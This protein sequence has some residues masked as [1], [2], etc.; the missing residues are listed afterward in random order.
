M[1]PANGPLRVHTEGAYYD[2]DDDAKNSTDAENYS[3]SEE[4]DADANEP[5][6]L[7]GGKRNSV[8]KPTAKTPTHSDSEDDIYANEPNNVVSGKRDSV[9]K[10]PVAPVANIEKCAHR[11]PK[12]QPCNG[13]PVSA[14][15]SYCVR[16]TCKRSSCHSHKKSN[17][18]FCVKHTTKPSKKFFAKFAASYPNWKQGKF[19]QLSR[20][21]AEKKLTDKGSGG[22]PRDFDFVLRDSKGCVVISAYASH[23]S[24]F[25][26]NQIKK[27]YLRPEDSNTSTS[28][29]FSVQGKPSVQAKSLKDLVGS[30]LDDP[31]KAMEALSTHIKVY[32]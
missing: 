16:H 13:T 23:K 5:K 3:D 29:R 32:D 22:V 20:V 7:R 26:H 31:N 24:K 15:D 21:E 19:P 10:K 9:R 8:R 4:E 17:E 25:I 14:S 12:G 18:D 28:G 6:D 1:G 30:W 2:S 27:I 11:N